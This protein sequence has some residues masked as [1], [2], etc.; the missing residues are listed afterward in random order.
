VTHTTTVKLPTTKTATK[1]PVAAA[2]QIATTVAQAEHGSAIF[3]G[4]A[5]DWGLRPAGRIA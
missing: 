5:G 1:P 2:T 3:T 4:C